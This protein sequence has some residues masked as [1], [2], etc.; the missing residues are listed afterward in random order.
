MTSYGK[1]QN[2]ILWTNLSKAGTLKLYSVTQKHKLLTKFWVD[3]KINLSLDLKINSLLNIDSKKQTNKKKQEMLTLIHLF[4]FCL[5]Q[6]QWVQYMTKSSSRTKYPIQLK[7]L[8][9]KKIQTE[10]FG[11]NIFFVTTLKIKIWNKTIFW[12]S[13]LACDL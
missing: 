12:W 11:E 1:E 9:V 7:P 5:V 13:C 3:S 6:I 8:G 2:K 4:L 10:T